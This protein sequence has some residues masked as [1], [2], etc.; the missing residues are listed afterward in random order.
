MVDAFSLKLQRD[1]RKN[2]LAVDPA[3]G[4]TEKR[5]Y[6]SPYCGDETTTYSNRAKK[7]PIMNG[8][9]KS[10][11]EIPFR[12]FFSRSAASARKGPPPRGLPANQKPWEDAGW[13]FFPFS[14]FSSVPS[15]SCPSI[16]PFFP[17]R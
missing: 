13:G 16:P 2:A 4:K 6:F 8:K 1:K 10:L 9:E 11:N 15:A 12:L 7:Y 17:V 14:S 5:L 3:K